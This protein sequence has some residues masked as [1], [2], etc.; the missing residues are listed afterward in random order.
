MCI[1]TLTTLHMNIFMNVVYFSFKC[2]CL[3][4]INWSHGY[5]KVTCLIT[6]QMTKRQ[7]LDSHMTNCNAN[8][9]TNLSLSQASSLSFHL[10]STS[11][12]IRPAVNKA[13]PLSSNSSVYADTCMCVCEATQKT[14][15]T[16]NK[17]DMI[18]EKA[19]CTEN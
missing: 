17:Y 3:S 8:C 10:V 14:V 4:T 5:Y 9:L 18:I 19:I 13:A 16:I 11:C 7:F 12:S 2:R 15:S 1:F 6:H